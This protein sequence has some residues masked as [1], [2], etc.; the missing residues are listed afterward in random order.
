M[1]IAQDSNSHVL[2]NAN[3]VPNSILTRPGIAEILF[4]SKKIASATAGHHLD[5][6][7]D[8]SELDVATSILHLASTYHSQASEP[9][10]NNSVRTIGG[11]SQSRPATGLNK[12]KNLGKA[13][14]ALELWKVKQ[15]E[16]KLLD[17][18]IRISAVLW[19]SDGLGV[20]NFTEVWFC[21]LNCRGITH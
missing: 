4:G 19:M 17:N 12:F 14:Q 16:A 13:N 20:S 10:L 11:G 2:E 6:G 9:R 1:E 3:D 15:E 5:S 8:S 18:G 21:F 7:A